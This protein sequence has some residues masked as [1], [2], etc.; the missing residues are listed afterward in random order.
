MSLRLRIAVGTAAVAAFAAGFYLLIGYLSFSEILREDIQR[1]LQVWSSA[2]AGSLTIES[3][4]PV[5]TGADWPWLSGGA[6]VGFRVLKGNTIYAEGGVLPAAGERDWVWTRR[7]LEDGFELELAAYVGEY[8]KALAGQLRAGLVTLPLVVALASA[9]GWWLAGRIT[10]PIDQLA[11]AADQLSQM[12]FPDPVPP[13]PG[14]DELSRLAKSFNRMVYAVQGAIER[15]RAFTRY[16]SHELRTPLATIQAQLE[17]LEAGLT[18]QEKALPETRRAIA[19]MRGIL[20]GLLTLSRDPKVAL[21]P[22]PLNQLVRALVNDLGERA[23]RVR[24]H[25]PKETLWIEADEELFK[26]ALGNLLDNALKYSNGPVDVEA[27]SDGREAVVSVRDYGEGVKPEQMERMA[28]PF[29]RFQTRVSG[30]GLGLSLTKQAAQALGG[31]IGFEPAEPG[32]R[33]WLRLPLM[34]DLDA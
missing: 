6:S 12:Q 8:R 31:Q 25:L 3:G 29:V 18:P 20:E 24:L 9:L 23:G 13:P 30:T 28:D 27:T 32:L 7:P 1:N 15:E 26:R 19:R 22:L 17:A 2:I 33:A 4:S 16:A 34:E 21:E 10:K 14:G 5:L 11:S